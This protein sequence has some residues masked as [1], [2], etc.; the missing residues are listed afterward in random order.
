MSYLKSLSILPKQTPKGITFTY[1]APP[2]NIQAKSSQKLIARLTL[3]SSLEIKLTV[4]ITCFC[5]PK[6]PD[7]QILVF[8]VK[9]SSSIIMQKESCSVF[10]RDLDLGGIGVVNILTEEKKK[11]PKNSEENKSE[12]TAMNLPKKDCKLVYIMTENRKTSIED[13]SK[14]FGIKLVDLIELNAEP[15]PEL[16]A[17]YNEKTGKMKKRRAFLQNTKIFIRALKR[18]KGEESEY[19]YDEVSMGGEFSALKKKEEE[20][21]EKELDIPPPPVIKKQEYKTIG[22]NSFVLVFPSLKECEAFARKV[23]NLV[24]IIQKFGKEPI[25]NVE[26]SLMFQSSP[27]PSKIIS[28]STSSSTFPSASTQN[29]E[30]VKE[31]APK[32]GKKRLRV[33]FQDF[34]EEI[35]AEA[36]ANAKDEAVQEKDGKRRNLFFQ[37]QQQQ[38]QQTPENE[39]PEEIVYEIPEEPMEDFSKP[40][41]PKTSDFNLVAFLDEEYGNGSSFDMF[42]DDGL[43]GLSSN[44][45]PTKWTDEDE[46]VLE[47]FGG[48]WSWSEGE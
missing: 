17:L 7:V 16:Q 36:K 38:Q 33:R 40:K 14:R 13:I 35:E 37:Q 41:L 47:E 34:Q 29:S 23:K 2:N 39:I 46:K 21:L 44:I 42:D 11:E 24:P 20:K 10:F 26:K 22:C 4:H 48:F 12:E 3:C 6:P 8:M 15:L 43:E 19:E 27:S 1:N 45:K 9:K 28:P 32:R 18:E 25:G 30:V 31:E 5:Q